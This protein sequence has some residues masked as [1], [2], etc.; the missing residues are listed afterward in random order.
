M[1]HSFSCL[2]AAKWFM[3]VESSPESCIPHAF[4]PGLLLA[5]KVH[6]FASVLQSSW[7]REP[8][9]NAMQ[10][11]HSFSCYS[12]HSVGGFIVFIKLCL[13]FIYHFSAHLWLISQWLVSSFG[14]SYCFGFYLVVQVKWMNWWS[15]EI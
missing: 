8:W 11:Y 14:Y 13:G 1:V 4:W 5:L 3:K 7:H 10:S 9:C 6:L 2:F 15:W 12:I